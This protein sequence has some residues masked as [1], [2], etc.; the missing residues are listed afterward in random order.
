AGRADAVRRRRS[1]RGGGGEERDDGPGTD[2]VPAQQPVR[3]RAGAALCQITDGREEDRH[4]TDSHGPPP[5][6]GPA[7]LGGRGRRRRRVD[8]GVQRGGA[9][10]EARQR[11]GPAGGLAELLPDAAV[12]E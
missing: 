1:E 8:R 4:G 12:L 6:R 2:A 9:A 3:P 10:A 5:S 11:G 7:T